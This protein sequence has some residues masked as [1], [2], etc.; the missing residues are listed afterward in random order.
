[1]NR[2]PLGWFAL[3]SLG[4]LFSV[5]CGGGPPRDTIA[6]RQ[7]VSGTVTWQGKPLAWGTISFEPLTENPNAGTSADIEAGKFTI[8]RSRGPGPGTYRIRI[9]GGHNPADNPAVA[10]AATD[11]APP[12]SMVPEAYN[13][14][15]KLTAEVTKGGSN[16]HTFNLP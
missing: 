13:T 5:G 6:D 2:R 15:S 4:V 9:S 14:K 12:K 10:G 7:E 8:P 16:Q 1:M 11:D 3:V